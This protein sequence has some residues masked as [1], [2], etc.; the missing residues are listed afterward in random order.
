MEIDSIIT[1]AVLKE[2]KVV[3]YNQLIAEKQNDLD[4]LIAILD[5]QNIKEPKAWRQLQ[6]EIEGL[7]VQ[8]NDWV[9]KAKLKPH[10][11]HKIVILIEEMSEAA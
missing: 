3:D 1:H 11:N 7:R 9:M 2:V 8:A 5:R 6:S 4:Q 10:R